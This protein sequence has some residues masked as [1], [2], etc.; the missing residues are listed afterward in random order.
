MVGCTSAVLRL[1]DIRAANP[2]GLQ[3]RPVFGN[4][5]KLLVRGTHWRHEGEVRQVRVPLVFLQHANTSSAK[6][7][8]S[9]ECMGVGRIVD[10]VLVETALPQLSKII[11]DLTKSVAQRAPSKKALTM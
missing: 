8:G 7:E 3:S 5:P 4:A 11:E 6:N 10:I 2:N 1:G 9:T